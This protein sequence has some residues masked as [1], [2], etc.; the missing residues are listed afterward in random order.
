LGRALVLEEIMG[1]CGV[2]VDHSTLN[3]W[4]LKY[5]PLLE[6]EFTAQKRSVGS[7]WRLDEAYV[8]VKG[9]WKYLCGR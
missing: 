8:R 2:E 3:R 5:V 9:K 6:K 4:I 1:E 7:S